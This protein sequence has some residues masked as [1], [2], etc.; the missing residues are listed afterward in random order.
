MCN[1][2]TDDL[3]LDPDHQNKPTLI[4]VQQ[5]WDISLLFIPLHFYGFHHIKL[6]V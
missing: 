6:Q 5:L 2:Y 1:F 3:C 4:Q